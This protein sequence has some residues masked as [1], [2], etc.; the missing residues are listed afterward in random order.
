MTSSD[1]EQDRPDAAS[2][3]RPSAPGDSAAA[4]DSVAVEGTSEAECE[5]SGD[6]ERTGEPGV[7]DVGAE[8]VEDPSVPVVLSNPRR[9]QRDSSPGAEQQPESDGINDDT[10]DSGTAPQGATARQTSR[11][12]DAI[13]SEHDAQKHDAQADGSQRAGSQTGG[14]QASGS[15]TRGSQTGGTDDEAPAAGPS[16][17]EEPNSEPSHREGHGADS[18]DAQATADEAVPAEDSCDTEPA[19]DATA[20][21]QVKPANKRPA[22]DPA[23]WPS[24]KPLRSTSSPLDSL[25]TGGATPREAAAR[26]QDTKQPAGRAPQNGGPTQH[27]GQASS[28]GPTQPSSPR[29]PRPPAATGPARPAASTGQRVGARLAWQRIGRGLKTAP[30]AMG[31]VAAVLL[32]AVAWVATVQTQRSSPDQ[33][34]N[35]SQPELIGVLSDLDLRS[36]QLAAEKARLQQARDRLL[37]SG[38]QQAV[39]REQARQ[40]YEALA[41][42]AGTVPAAGPGVVVTIN[43][44]EGTVRAPDLVNAVQELRDA[45]AEAMQINDSRIT[46]STAFVGPAGQVRVD[47]RLLTHPIKLKAIGDGQT[48]KTAL[49]FRGGMKAT[50]EKRPGAS[51]DIQA[52][53]K[54]KVTAV[55]G[56]RTARFARPV[57]TPTI[58]GS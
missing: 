55:I 36:S 20:P 12:D 24:G 30:T 25:A 37:G 42:L 57:S 18:T 49:T 50:V 1:E 14:S 41:I 7:D 29:Q 35:L 47:G 26:A 5:V 44:P 56:D 11:A 40:R 32:M 43:D 52:V 58:G 38:D 53:S 6:Y 13:D 28:E 48:L 45:G 34:E 15:Q 31:S 9:L 8:V 23:N 46:V 4:A 16:H 17:V 27:D 39:A 10:A 21:S 2:E 33:L 3:A 19:G 22:H 51:V 54:V